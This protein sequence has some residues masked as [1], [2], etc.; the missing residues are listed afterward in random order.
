MSSILLVHR[1]AISRWI[2]GKLVEMEVTQ[3]QPL[4]LHLKLLALGSDGG[5]IVSCRELPKSPRKCDF[6]YLLSN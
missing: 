5:V 2:W 4:H 1:S 6:L 3:L